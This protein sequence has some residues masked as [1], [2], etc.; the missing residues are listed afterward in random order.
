MNEY[1]ILTFDVISAA[2]L[3]YIGYHVALEVWCFLY[4]LVM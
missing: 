4:G 3:A 1:T 2:I